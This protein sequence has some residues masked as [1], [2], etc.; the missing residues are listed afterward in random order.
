MPVVFKYRRMS[1]LV[2]VLAALTALAAC[3]P[4]TQT[5]DGPPPTFTPIPTFSFTEPTAPPAVATSA[6]ATAAARAAEVAALDPVAVERGR[7]RY[8]VLEC[9]SC[10]GENG[11]GSA[12]GPSLLTST[13][14]LDSFIGYMRS[15]GPLGAAHQY[16]TNRLSDSGG[17]NLYQYLVS[18]RQEQE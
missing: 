16:S 8:E 12:N 2:V 1:P 18:I 14:D 11:E 13:L 7:G 10:H 6:A 5:P 3:S 9:A 17:R 4:G 15:G